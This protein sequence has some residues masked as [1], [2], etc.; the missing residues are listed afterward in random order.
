MRASL[1]AYE[2]K[3]IDEPVIPAPIAPRNQASR[4]HSWWTDERGPATFSQV[5]SVWLRQCSARRRLQWWRSGVPA[6]GGGAD[7]ER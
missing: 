5:C 2:E 1:R 3:E 4:G 7:G 6:P